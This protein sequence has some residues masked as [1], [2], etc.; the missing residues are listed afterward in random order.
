MSTRVRDLL[1]AF[2]G[3]FERNGWHGPSVLGALRGLDPKKAGRR[4]QRAHHTIHE[5]VE[6]VAYWEERALAYF[7]PREKAT[8]QNFGAPVRSFRASVAH[9]KSVHTRLIEKIRRLRE[10]DL[11]RKLRGKSLARVL[12]GVAAHATY[13][14]G[15]IGLLKTLL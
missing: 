4:P 2:E 9:M 7:A 14:A 3:A 11:D 5:L 6:H 8:G 15:Q 10:K 1:E 12:H 13:H